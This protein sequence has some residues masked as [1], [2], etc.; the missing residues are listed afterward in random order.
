MGAKKRK[1]TDV[2][3]N[4]LGGLE[5][6]FAEPKVIGLDEPLSAGL[7]PPRWWEQNASAPMEPRTPILTVSPQ[8]AEV[9][10]IG[11]DRMVDVTARLRLDFDFTA[12][13]LTHYRW[14]Y[15]RIRKFLQNA[16]D[17]LSVASPA[18]SVDA[19]IVGVRSAIQQLLEEGMP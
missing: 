4:L 10:N 1:P 5:A 7:L 18:E 12:T 2:R 9:L 3:E 13:R 15:E 11:I 6:Q 16:S 19:A 8:V 14:E 17:R